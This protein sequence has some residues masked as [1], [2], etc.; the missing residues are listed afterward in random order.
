MNVVGLIVEYNPLHNG[1]QYHY[2]Q[3][4]KVTNA[5]AVVIIMSGNFLQRGE[6]ALVNKWARTEMAL[7]MGVDLVIELPY[8]YSTQQAQHFAFG[9]VSLLNQLPFVTHLCFGSE[10]GELDSL[11]TM[12]KLLVSEPNSFKETLRHKLSEGN[13]YPKAYGESLVQLS[14]DKSL[15]P[16]LFSQPNNILGLHYLMSLLK[17]KSSIIP[18]TIKREKAGY[19]EKEFVDQK[20]ASATGIRQAL[21]SSTIPDWAKIKPFLPD[22]TLD[23]LQREATRGRGPVNWENYY[24]YLIQSFL[25]QSSKHLN[26]IY[27]MEEGIENRFKSKAKEAESLEELCHLVKSKRYTWNRIQRMMLHAYTQFTKE[28]AIRLKLENGPSYLR[29]LG[30][31]NKGKELLNQHKKKLSIP[32]ISSVRKQHPPMLDWDI[33]ASL[34]HTLGYS[35]EAFL[36]EKNREQKQPPLSIFKD[37]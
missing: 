34:L 28:E 9:A 36:E 19:H 18:T 4:K 33:K 24:S 37:I 29:L 22:Y 16:S 8:V 25:S 17:L 27:E 26:S 30:Y 13:S 7:H 5:D 12:A 14:K 6:P 23:I 2:E 10:S 20:I 11:Q 15:D 31:S 3:S 1:H 32:L 35:P 21:F